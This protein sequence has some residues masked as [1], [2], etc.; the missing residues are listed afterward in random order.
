MH[1]PLNIFFSYEFL[2]LSPSLR[3]KLVD[4]APKQQQAAGPAV[5]FNG[6]N[7]GNGQQVQTKKKKKIV[8]TTK[9]TMTFCQNNDQHFRPTATAMVTV[10]VT[11]MASMGTT[12]SSRTVK[13]KV[14]LKRQVNQPG[15]RKLFSDS[16]TSI[17]RSY[18][19]MVVF[20]E[21]FPCFLRLKF[22]IHLS[23]LSRS[24]HLW[25]YVLSAMLLLRVFPGDHL[26]I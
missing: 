7:N 11:A 24:Q 13:V 21:L 22:T 26:T 9:K 23:R 2:I 15:T 3:M 14:M 5:R 18:F 16:L 12:P 8:G 19:W 1:I 17:Q 4:E 10:M 25:C 20:V 6:V